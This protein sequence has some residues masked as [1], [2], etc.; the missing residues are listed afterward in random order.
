M[1]AMEKIK[2][3]IFQS[4]NCSIYSKHFSF[5]QKNVIKIAY[6]AKSILSEKKIILKL[7]KILTLVV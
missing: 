3:K 5:F 2:A 1:S 6:M 4:S 7:K